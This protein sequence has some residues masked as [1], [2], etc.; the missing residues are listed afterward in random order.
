MQLN[1]IKRLTAQTHIGII[2]WNRSYSSVPVSSPP[3]LHDADYQ[4]LYNLLQSGKT[5]MDIKTLCKIH[6]RIVTFGYGTSPSLMASLMLKYV[7]RNRRGIVYKITGQV[8][9]WSIDLVELNM[10]IDKLLRMENYRV[11]KMVFNKMP[12]R[13]VVTWN[14]MIGG[15]VRKA[16]FEEALRLF[17][18]M[19]KSNVEPDKFTFASV[20]NGTYKQPKLGEAAMANISRLRSGDYV[21]LSNIYCS[22]KRWDTAQGVWE[23][24]K[25]KGVRKVRGKSCFEWAGVLHPFKAGDRSH[26]E[27]E[28]IY[29]MLEGLIQR[30]KL[31]GYVPTTDLVTMD[32]SEEE[33]EGNLYHHSEKLALAYGILKT[34]SG[35][36]VRISKNLRI[37]YD[38]HN[39]IKMVSRLL[40]RVIIVRDRIR[41]HQFENGLCSCG[42]LLVEVP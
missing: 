33:K 16:R 1:V 31:A 34:T 5:S 32:V 14:T 21:L 25:K 36:E 17:R 41:F 13:D 30:T 9:C 11:A 40:S 20:M 38:C 24:M 8:F 39:W 10:I 12:S 26:P 22:Q 7:H 3:Q 6:S 15:Y 4:E 42:R 2:R 19:I 37:C 35:S 29:K 23:M 28:E 27:T 18:F